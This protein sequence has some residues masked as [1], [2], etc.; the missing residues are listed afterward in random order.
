MTIPS[1]TEQDFAV[2]QIQGLEHRMDGLKKQIQPKFEVFGEAISSFLT[3]QL[4]QDTYVHIAKHA[5][6]TVNPPDETWVAWSTNN[7]GY[8]A[9]PHFQLGLRDTELF[10][11]FA[12]IYECEQ[13]PTFA[14]NLKEQLPEILPTIPSSYYLS[15]DHTKPDVTPL[16]EMSEKDMVQALDRLENVKKAEFLVGMVLPRA[17]VTKT[18]GSRLVERVEETFSTLLSLY[19]LAAR[20]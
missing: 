1:F 2:F 8:K 19:R 20:R 12:L 18:S 10:A 11:Y 7:R 14:R 4:K 3:T 16:K 9:H 17:E 6:R 5:R 15:L 13:K